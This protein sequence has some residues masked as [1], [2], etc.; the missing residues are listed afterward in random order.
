MS[1]TPN[2]PSDGESLAESSATDSVTESTSGSTAEP[3]S[4]NTELAAQVDLLTAE[5]RRLREM[6]AAAQRSRYRGTAI[7]LC[8]IGLL[9]GLFGYFMP[10]GS[11]VLFALAGTGVFGGV[12]TYFLTPERFIS[13]DVGQRVYTASA[14][15]F[16]RLC[17][18]LGLS[19]RRVY[20]PTVYSSEGTQPDS[21][22][23]WLFIPQDEET[24]IP[25]PADVDSALVVDDNKR[26]LSVRP[27]GSGLFSALSTSLTEPLGS[28]AETLCAQLSDALVEDF[29]LG[30]SVVYETDPADGRV[31][32]RISGAL[33]GD[34]SRF[35]HPI[36]S[37][38]AVG[39]A[40]GLETPVETT[41][42]ATEPLSVTLRWEQTTVD[43]DSTAE[44]S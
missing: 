17:T 3:V 8:G 9:C 33:Y 30:Q 38:L 41:I 16:E 32:F 2:S 42:T 11:T 7:A 20:I 18:D 36:V 35:D 27:T 37:L 28:T 31:S 39:L 6:V 1:N 43:K 25:E 5:N 13:A 26:G 34:G 4:Q 24:S 40:T 12:L 10:T 44:S 14:E 21:A 19:D 15:S 29:E 22:D 23:G